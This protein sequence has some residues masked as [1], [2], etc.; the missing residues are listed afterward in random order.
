[1]RRG[2]ATGDGSDVRH[3]SSSR[4]DSQ[5]RG[6][7]RKRTDNLTATLKRYAYYMSVQVSD[8]DALTFN[9]RLVTNSFLHVRAL[10]SQ[11]YTTSYHV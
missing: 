1:M 9:K 5:L 8:L 2:Q 10:D 4:D 7:G 3:A 11:I 6:Q